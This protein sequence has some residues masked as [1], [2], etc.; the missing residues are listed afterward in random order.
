MAKEETEFLCQRCT[1]CCRWP[2]DVVLLDGEVE[3]IAEYVGVP[4]YEF[5][6]DYTYLRANRAGLSLR[7]KEGTTECVMLEGDRC[8]IQAVKPDQCR[9]F[10]NRW[11][12]PGW[13]EVC[14]A[15]EVPKGT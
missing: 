9:G 8:R 4:L 6:R 13:R 15:I 12:F 14:E 3:K 5:V 7:E 10:P 2:G 1:A 11:N